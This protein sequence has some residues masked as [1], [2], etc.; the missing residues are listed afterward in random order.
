MARFSGMIYIEQTS[1]LYSGMIYIEQTSNL[2]RFCILYNLDQLGYM[3]YIMKNI[4]IFSKTVDM[5]AR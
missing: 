3:I 1:N 4:C 2:W 5:M